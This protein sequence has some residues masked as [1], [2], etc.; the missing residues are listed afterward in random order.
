MKCDRCGEER[1]SS[2][3]RLPQGW[4]RHEGAAHCGACVKKGFALRAVALPVLGVLA[5]GSEEEFRAAMEDAFRTSTD[6]WNW[7]TRRLL[8][9]DVTRTPTME[10]MPPAPKV[11]LYKLYNEEGRPI[12]NLATRSRTAL[13]RM[14]QTA[15][16]RARYESLWLGRQALPLKRFPAPF[17]VHNQGWRAMVVEERPALLFRLHG[18]ESGPQWVVRLASGAPFRRHLA[19]FRQIAAGEAIRAQLDLYVQGCGRDDRGG[20]YLNWRKTSGGQRTPERLMAKL[21]ARFPRRAPS[22]AEGCMLLR[23]DPECFWVAEVE[24]R[25]ERPWIL[26]GDHVLQ[27]LGMMRDWRRRHAAWLQRIG[28]DRKHE[29]RWP[30]AERRQFADAYARRCEKHDRRMKTWID[31]MVA[32]AVQFARRRGV[33]TIAYQ[34]DDR[35]TADFPW[36][37]LRAALARR[38]DADGIELIARESQ[39]DER[40]TGAL[41]QVGG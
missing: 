15:Y 22:P 4:K 25:V 13:F 36:F 19:Q 40:S 30:I 18:Q 20:I 28:E 39:G 12:G 26:N 6:C 7:A 21:V 5:G 1:K 17:P 32:Q 14:A 3:N 37:Q 23:T 31:Q 10:R 27:S 11:D 9:R 8:E 38:C 35:V 24:G 16:G 34:D 29:K 2:K 33:A 41:S